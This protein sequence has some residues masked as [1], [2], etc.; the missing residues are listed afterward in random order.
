MLWN[1][2]AKEMVKYSSFICNEFIIYN[3]FKIYEKHRF[4]TKH[5]TEGIPTSAILFIKTQRCNGRFV[6]P[7]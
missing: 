3:E 4:A 6:F 5:E 7:S 1:N 2:T